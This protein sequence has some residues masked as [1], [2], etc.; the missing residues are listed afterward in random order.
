MACLLLSNQG[1]SLRAK[2]TPGD[3]GREVEKVEVLKGI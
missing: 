2:P 1:E 3:A